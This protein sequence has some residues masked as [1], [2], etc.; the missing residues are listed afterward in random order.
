M[1]FQLL[2]AL[3][4][5]VRLAAAVAAAPPTSY[6]EVI[7]GPGFPTLASLGLISAELYSESPVVRAWF[8]V[9]NRAH[10]T[11]LSV[12]PPEKRA[13]L[14]DA[15]CQTYTT[16]DVDNVIA[17]FNYLAKIGGNCVVHGE[18]VNFC[19]VGDAAVTGSNTSGENSA[20][21]S[22]YAGAF[23]FFFG[24]VEIGDWCA[25]PGG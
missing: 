6:P 23:S 21:S 17:C 25:K 16:A 10:T 19:T 7:P 13:V 20:S 2:P 18:N 11:D 14:Y 12:T 15:V 1:V 3:M 9:L 5:L 24:F 4:L 8:P 22:W